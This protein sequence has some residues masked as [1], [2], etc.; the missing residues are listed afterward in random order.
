MVSRT[1]MMAASSAATVSSGRLRI[2]VPPVVSAF[3]AGRESAPWQTPRAANN[4][5]TR[6]SVSSPLERTHRL[7]DRTA[8]I[9]NLGETRDV[10]AL[11]AGRADAHLSELDGPS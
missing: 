6:R 5:G 4:P 1:P 8:G 7:C 9:H 10:N 11:S 3:I 2:G